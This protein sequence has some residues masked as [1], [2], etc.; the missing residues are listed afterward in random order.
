MNPAFGH[1]YPGLGFLFENIEDLTNPKVVK[2]KYQR[3]VFERYKQHPHKAKAFSCSEH[4][5]K[6]V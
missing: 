5:Y 4:I 3:Q 1:R 6:H 2:A